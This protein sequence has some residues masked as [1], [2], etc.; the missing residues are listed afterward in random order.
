MN[1]LNSDAKYT[2]GR[3]KEE[4]ERLIQQSQLYGRLTQ[5]FLQ[6]AGIVSGMKVLDVGSGAGDVA[7]AVAE[8]VGS[9]G[10]VVGV[11]VNEGI[12]NTGRKRAK[13]SGLVNITFIEGDARSLS[14][15]EQ[16]DAVVGRLVLMYMSEPAEALKQLST[17]L[18][19][20][21][22]VAFQELDFTSFVQNVHPDTPLIN[23]LQKWCIDVFQRSGAHI[24]M[25]LELYRAF[26]DAGLPEP[27]L[28]LSAPAGGPEMWSGYE[29]VANSF[30]SMLPLIEDYGIATSEEVEIETLTERLRREV[31]LS[32]RPIVL[33]LHVTA[34]AQLPK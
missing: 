5:R 13:Q 23:T 12:L 26:M 7:L 34:W 2:M 9:E 25:G 22:I 32:K 28:Y 15:E 16:F 1:E 10:K 17:H 33:P 14:F 29:Y 24:G 6:E 21:G 4:T 30:R 11:D 19:S 8:L 31:V 27:S 20:G 3:S 18:C